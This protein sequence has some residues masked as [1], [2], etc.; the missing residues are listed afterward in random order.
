MSLL[1]RLSLKHGVVALLAFILT[2]VVVFFTVHSEYTGSFIPRVFSRVSQ[3]FSQDYELFH[4]I[5]GFHVFG[6]GVIESYN[7]DPWFVVLVDPSVA[8]NLLHIYIS[9][10]RHEGEA[11]ES[12]LAEIFYARE[13]E[14]F[15]WS[16]MALFELK[17]GMNVVELPYDNYAR[18]RLDLAV[19]PHVSMIVEMVAFSNY[20]MLS[21]DFLLICLISWFVCIILAILLLRMYLNILVSNSDEQKTT[22]FH[23]SGGR[24]LYVISS[25]CLPGIFLFDLYNRNRSLNNIEFV[26]VVVWV[27]I[28]MLVSI[29]IF[30]L[31]HLMTQSPEGAF[32]LVLVF[33]LLFWLFE[34]IFNAIFSHFSLLPRPI[35]QL[36]LSVVWLVISLILQRCK[37]HIVKTSIGLRPLAFCLL[38]FFLINLVPGLQ[39]EIMFR[40]A[41]MMAEERSREFYIKREFYVDPQLPKPDIYWFHMDG[42]MSLE[43]FERFWGESKEHL[44]NELVNM[45][46]QIYT[47]SK[48]NAGKSEHAIAALLSPALYSS[49]LHFIFSETQEMFEESNGLLGRNWL[50]PIHD[51][52]MTEDGINI[53]SDIMPYHELLSALSYVGY[54]IIDFKYNIDLYRLTDYDNII[55]RIL[56]RFLASDLPELLNRTTPLMLPTDVIQTRTRDS[57]Y[58]Y[59][60][61]YAPRF[62]WRTCLQAHIGKF[63]THDPDLNEYVEGHFRHDLYP[64]AF[65]VA[66]EEM[67]RDIEIILANN[68]NAVIVLQSDHGFHYSVMHRQ[69]LNDGFSIEEVLDLTFSVFSAVRIPPQYGGLG[70][71]LAPLNISRELVNRFVGENYTLLP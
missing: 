40:T 41:G 42:L 63:Y 43:V 70:A 31:S 54:E 62:V 27:V 51:E 5:H 49:Y 24:L 35:L 15:H 50:S 66:V 44:R 25:I 6:D 29:L 34:A 22:S 11:I 46:F 68:P 19:I 56:N 33:W 69:L 4:T 12:T 17:N 28:F 64:I 57:V 52:I 21:N 7:D 38:V 48:L 71:P 61:E 59:S 53:W 9:D 2:C 45:G 10:L 55:I 32:I 58:T 20:H 47:N 30:K 37:I 26:H 39:N 65:T 36:C 8:S 3:S 13:G 16:R 23:S 60:H 14:H 1:V 18:L 67:L